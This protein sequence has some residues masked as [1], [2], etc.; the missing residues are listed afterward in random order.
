MSNAINTAKTAKTANNA[1]SEAIAETWCDFEVR[2]KRAERHPVFAD[3]VWY[4]NVA[5]AFRALRLPMSAHIG[6]RQVLVRESLASYEAHLF[7]LAE[8]WGC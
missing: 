4:A 2:A 8:V 1:R 3:G 5:K 6:F 7:A